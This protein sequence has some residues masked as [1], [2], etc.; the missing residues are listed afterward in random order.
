MDLFDWFEEDD[1]PSETA[2]R[3]RVRLTQLPEEIKQYST[4]EFGTEVERIEFLLLKGQPLQQAAAFRSLHKVLSEPN[5]SRVIEAF[6]KMLPS[7]DDAIKIEAGL[8]LTKAAKAIILRSS[9]A[10]QLIPLIVFML[11]TLQSEGRQV[12]LECFIEIVR[13]ATPEVV[14]EHCTKAC[15]LIGDFA[16]SIASRETAAHMLGGIAE[17]VQNDLAPELFT[18]VLKLAQ[19]PRFEV[20]KAM[21]QE[22]KN[23]ISSVTE[24][25]L[26]ALLIEE[27]IQLARDEV[28]EVKLE[29]F[30]MLTHVLDSFPYDVNITQVIPLI[31]AE[32]LRSNDQTLLKHS[33]KIIGFLLSKLEAELSEEPF[34]SNIISFILKLAQNTDAEARAALVKAFPLLIVTFGQMTFLSQLSSAYTRLVEDDNSLVQ[35]AVTWSFC[36][37]MR[38]LGNPDI[39]KPNFLHLLGQ[40]GLIAKL[41]VHMPDIVKTFNDSNINSEVSSKLVDYLSEKSISWR[42]KV[43]ILKGIQRLVNVLDP[44]IVPRLTYSLLDLAHSAIRPVALSALECLTFTLRKS[45]RQLRG[46]VLDAMTLLQEDTHFKSRMLFLDFAELYGKS[47]S[48]RLFKE[49][50]IDLILPL[51][52]DPVSDVRFKLA[53]AFP[54]FR[55][56]ISNED[57]ETSTQFMQSLDVLLYD[58]S[59]AVA[60]CA[61]ESQSAF[62]NRNFW[63]KIGSDEEERL[64]RLKRNEELEQERREMQAEEEEKKRVV[65]KLAQ[66]AKM[67]FLTNKTKTATAGLKRQNSK[68]LPSLDKPRKVRLE[69]R[70]TEAALSSTLKGV[71][72][73]QLT[74]SMTLPRLP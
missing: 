54:V 69:R 7:C 55:Q 56:F 70:K 63:K 16:N 59:T 50:L 39:L 71:T 65:E 67:D 43:G 60:R 12:W 19:D 48:R 14:S 73:R 38:L 10:D 49:K 52:R 6:I 41:I 1:R 72:P 31:E 13:S 26:R 24:P 25:N 3:V 15:L 37:V 62:M 58:R 36:E 8:G 4:E 27:A 42:T 57:T 33:C 30:T 32:M 23:I 29:A 74:K 22:L 64:D 35:E 40:P 11:R 9:Q 18:R 68:I 51:I 28:L 5:S 17:V 44:Q 53:K 21:S 34:R 20:R 66:K 2:H 61:G 45:P 47:H 46:E